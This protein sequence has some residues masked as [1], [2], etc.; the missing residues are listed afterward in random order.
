MKKKDKFVET[1]KTTSKIKS[2]EIYENAIVVNIHNSEINDTKQ[3]NFK[4]YQLVTLLEIG[5]F[6]GL[7]DNGKYYDMIERLVISS[8]NIFPTVF[9]PI[10][11]LWDRLYNVKPLQNDA[12]LIKMAC[13]YYKLNEKHILELSKMRKTSIQISRILD[14]NKLSKDEFEKINNG[15]IYQ[16]HYTEFIFTFYK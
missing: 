3:I 2:N 14:I 12:E 13:F 1:S 5:S 6:G 10:L 9:D 4:K 8:K 7:D 11:P 15:K 16:P